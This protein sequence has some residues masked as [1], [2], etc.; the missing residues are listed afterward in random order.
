MIIQ[1]NR[2]DRG[3]SKWKSEFE[4]AALRVLNSGWYVL[5]GEVK[6]FE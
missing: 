6:A 1:A 2:L 4:E 3:F 5:G